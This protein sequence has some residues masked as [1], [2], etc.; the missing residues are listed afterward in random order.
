MKNGKDHLSVSFF[1]L[2]LS[3]FKIRINIT[4][5]CS[6]RYSYHQLKGSRFLE[7]PSL[8]FRELEAKD[9]GFN[10]KQTS[11]RTEKMN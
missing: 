11:R 10:K 2:S 7:S 5:R 6:V 9:I 3:T 1:P 8:L 4:K